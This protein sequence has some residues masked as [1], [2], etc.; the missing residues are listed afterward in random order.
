MYLQGRMPHTTDTGTQHAA[1]HAIH[2]NTCTRFCYHTT[3][4]RIRTMSDEQ[5]EKRINKI[6]NTLKMQSLVLVSSSPACRPL[7]R[8]QYVPCALQAL[9]C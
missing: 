9:I 1:V 6:T 3:K 8:L 7:S 2:E 5:L 4:R